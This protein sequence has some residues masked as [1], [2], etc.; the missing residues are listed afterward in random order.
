MSPDVSA[1]DKFAAL[2]V[3]GVAPLL[4]AIFSND[5]TTPVLGVGVTTVVGA[6]LGTAGALG[7]DDKKPPRGVM[8]TRTLATVIIASLLVGAIP[9]WLGWTWSSGPAEA[10]LC[11]LAAVVVYFLLPPA[12]ERGREI[13]RGLKLSDFIPWMR[14]RADTPDPTPAPADPPSPMPPPEPAPPSSEDPEK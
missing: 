3:G 4:P 2:A 1:L 9:R 6:V 11:G 13:I 12:I 5:L 7:Y 10:A 14:K 8:F